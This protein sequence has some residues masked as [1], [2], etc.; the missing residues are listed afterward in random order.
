MTAPVREQC[1]HW[2]NKGQC[3]IP[4]CPDG[5]SPIGPSQ[6]QPEPTM[7]ELALAF[8]LKNPKLSE[9]GTQEL[10]IVAQRL[11]IDNVRLNA[12]MLSIE[13]ET[14]AAERKKEQEQEQRVRENKESIRAKRT[15]YDQDR[16]ERMDAL[17]SGTLTE[18]S[19]KFL[20]K[21]TESAMDDLDGIPDP[22]PVIDGL[23]YRGTVNYLAGA[24]GAFKTIVAL[25]MAARVAMSLDFCGMPVTPGRAL[26]VIAEGLSGMKFRKRAW[27]EC[28]NRGQKIPV[29][30]RMRFIPFAVQIGDLDA[31]M[32]ALIAFA[33]EG[34]Y[35]FIVFDTQAMCTLGI[36]ENDNDEMAMVIDAALRLCQATGGCVLIVAHTGQDESKGI[37]GASGQYANVNTVIAS[38]RDG[39]TMNITLSTARAKGGKQKDAR[40]IK[41]MR[42]AVTEVGP[43]VA[44][45]QGVMDVDTPKGAP[46]KGFDTEPPREVCEAVMGF[47]A[48]SPKCGSR[49]IRTGVR[50]GRTDVKDWA[51]KW[52]VTHGYIAAEQVGRKVE[53]QVLMALQY[54]QES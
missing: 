25:D 12:A 29:D 54:D 17:A 47:V 39:S 50:T 41:A 53:H 22:V 36:K 34:G 42:F 33:R 43:S 4:G 23:L 2:Q 40:E 45:G 48:S 46:D 9:R 7:A 16:A 15:A 30:G 35:D 51:V 6:Q 11:G 13:S 24:S 44:L 3:N 8:S 31:E 26:Y 21:L 1:Q 27:E 5:L 37:R 52:L 28:H 14:E 49:D 18:S 10:V 38:K 20:A 19:T 32:P